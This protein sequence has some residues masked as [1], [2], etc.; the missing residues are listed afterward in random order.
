MNRK[1]IITLVVVCLLSGFATLR[2]QTA[3]TLYGGQLAEV[4]IKS[5][6]LNDTERYHYNQ[7]KFYITT[8]LP[9][10]NAS[11]ALFNEINA[12]ANDPKVSKRE[13]KQFIARKQEEMKTQFEDK[14]KALNTTQ[15]ELLIKLIARQTDLNLYKMVSEVKNPIAAMKWQSWALVHGM[16]L[17]RKYHPEE[18]PML[19]NIM[20]ELGYPLPA[21]YAVN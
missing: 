16:N 8:I 20:E 11:T 3:D 2:A 14:I 19:E 1:L 5:K 12:K 15:G 21:S 9:Y 17:D 6:W 18:E 7:T 4:K 10:L 13:Y